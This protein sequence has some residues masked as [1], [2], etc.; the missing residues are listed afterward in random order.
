MNNFSF[1]LLLVTLIAGV[2]L[3]FANTSSAR[4]LSKDEVQILDSIA[5]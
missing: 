5:N 1:K 4:E 2:V 3:A